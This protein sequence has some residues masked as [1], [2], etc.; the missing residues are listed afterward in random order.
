MTLPL[1]TRQPL[2][3]SGAPG[4]RPQRPFLVRH[5]HTGARDSRHAPVACH[6]QR[7]S[8]SSTRPTLARLVYELPRTSSASNCHEAHTGVEVTDPHLSLALRYPAHTV[9]AGAVQHG[10]SPE[11]TSI[12]S[13]RL[14]SGHQRRITRDSP[15]PQMPRGL[16]M[17]RGV[18]KLSRPRS[19][20]A[21]PWHGT[22]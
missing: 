18:E 10:P 19:H 21:R 16:S 12:R 4:P 3:G 2:S 1:S 9:H 17:L 20:R 11:G 13:S 22:I 5:I 14:A 8:P 6:Y 7:P 15:G